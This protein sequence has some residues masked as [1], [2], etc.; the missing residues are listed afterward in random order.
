MGL[1]SLGS[2]PTAIVTVYFLGQFTLEGPAVETL[3]HIVLG[4]A[5]ILTSMAILF[6]TVMHDLGEKVKTLVPQWIRL[7]PLITVLAGIILGVLVPI[8]SI[9][10]G[11]LGAAMLLFLY[12]SLPTM[13][14]VGTDLAHAVP[15]TAI[16]G[17]G[18]WQLGSVDFTLLLYLLIGSL[19]GIYLGQS[20]EHNYPGKNHATDPGKHAVVDWS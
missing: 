3:I 20:Y 19:P 11:A 15:L 8:S 14:I 18:H 6:K 10:A 2:L 13:R 16:A 12:P 17:L 1:L 4:V 9:G 5:L 7:R